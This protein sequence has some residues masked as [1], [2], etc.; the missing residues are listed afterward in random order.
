MFQ[1]YKKR[2]FSAYIT[3]TIAF[4]KIYWKNFFGNYIVITGALLALLCLFYFFI[5]RDL[6]S[7]LFSTAN[8]GIGYDIGYYFSDNPVL[9]VSVMVVVALFAIFFSIFSIAYP[10]IYLK[11]IEETGKKDF[12]A[13]EIFGRIKLYLPK[14][15]RF[16]FYSF[17]TFFPLIFV[18]GFF[19]ALLVLLVVGVFVLILLIPVASVWMTQSFYIYLLQEM[20]FFEAIKQGWKNLFS[21]K[22]WHIV[23]AAMVIYVVLS[24]LQG[25]ITMI[26]YSI[27][28]FSMLATGD[29][30]LGS[31]FGVIISVLYIVSLLFSYITSNILMVNQG[32]VYYSILEQNNHVQALSEINLIGQNVE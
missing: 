18:A 21:K 29:G 6:F 25:M 31:S 9:F 14:I 1:L 26:P 16:G 8:E 2:D 30:K 7:A 27:M 10:V 3:D 5:F 19:A 24:V 32:V 13:S 12:T 17:I 20:S 15:I 11:L 22:F 4:F 23:G 28:L